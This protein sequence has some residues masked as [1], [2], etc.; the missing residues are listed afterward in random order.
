MLGSMEFRLSD[1][2]C[3]FARD[4]KESRD[5]TSRETTVI[6]LPCMGLRCFFNVFLSL[7]FLWTAVSVGIAA[8]FFATQPRTF[9]NVV[10]IPK[11]MHSNFGSTFREVRK[12]RNIEFLVFKNTHAHSGKPRLHRRLRES[13]A[14][15]RFCRAYRNRNCNIF[16]FFRKANL[17][18]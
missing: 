18:L 10:A 4:W 13:Q 12:G 7:A 3:H 11:H 17:C 16:F 6:T 9:W 1:K 14:Y 8:P 2:C 5:Y 15:G